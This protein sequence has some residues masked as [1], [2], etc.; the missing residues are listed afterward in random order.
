V[1]V[2]VQFVESGREENCGI[3]TS[4]RTLE[5]PDDSKAAVDDVIVCSSLA[6]CKS[7]CRMQE[8]AVT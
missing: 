7:T 2:D 4:I 3:G 8:V 1:E 6:F 5:V